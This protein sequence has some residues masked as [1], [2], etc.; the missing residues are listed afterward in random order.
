MALS[1][2]QIDLLVRKEDA[3]AAAE[4]MMRETKNSLLFQFRWEDLLMSSPVALNCISAC[5][6]AAGSPDANVTLT[7]PRDGFKYL[8]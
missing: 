2:Q 4:R 3:G 5:I 1:P 6:V 8:V 7:P